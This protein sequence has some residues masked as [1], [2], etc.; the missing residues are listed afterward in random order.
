MTSMR[1]YDERQ[2]AVKYKTGLECLVLGCVITFLM[3]LLLSFGFY[4]EDIADVCN[5]IFMMI[6]G[7]YIIRGIQKDAIFQVHSQKVGIGKYLMAALFLILGLVLVVLS[8]QEGI[9]IHK[10]V[11]PYGTLGFCMGMVTMIEG[12]GFLW[13]VEKLRRD[14]MDA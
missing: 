10:K 2:L 12:I 5:T 7:Y 13:Y 14:E 6:L 1:N 3:I 8:L 4:F 11:I 9:F